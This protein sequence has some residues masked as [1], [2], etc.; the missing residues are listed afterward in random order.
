MQVAGVLCVKYMYKRS[1]E[2]QLFFYNLNIQKLWNAFKY[3]S[4]YFNYFG[5]VW[6]GQSVVSV[7]SPITRYLMKWKSRLTPMPYVTVGIDISIISMNIALS[8]H[9]SGKKNAPTGCWWNHDI[10]L[11][12]PETLSNQSIATTFLPIIKTKHIKSLSE[13]Q[14]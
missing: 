2:G 9:F 4:S 12:P 3:W 10:N 6:P 13:L 11:E 14:F 1:T 5:K 7:F 8:A